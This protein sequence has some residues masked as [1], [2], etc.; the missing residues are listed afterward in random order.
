MYEGQNPMIVKI[1]NALNPELSKMIIPIGAPDSLL[2]VKDAVD[3]GNAVGM[4]GDR[5]MDEKKEKTV[6]C[7]LLGDEVVLPAA[8]ILIA[9]TLKVPIIVFF[10]IYKGG[11]CYQLHFKLLAENIQLDREQRQQDIQYWMQEYAN[12]LEEQIKA[13]PFNWFNFYDYWQEL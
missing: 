3:E 9:A 4:L 8:P 2:Q 12:I 10:G 7:T 6:T 13:S 1:L 11:N 5:V